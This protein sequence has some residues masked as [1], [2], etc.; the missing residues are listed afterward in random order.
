VRFPPAA[1]TAPIALDD[2]NLLGRSRRS[3]EQFYKID[4]RAELPLIEQDRF[5]AIRH[6]AL[7]LPSMRS[8]TAY[9]YVARR[10]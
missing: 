7:D 1:I 10:G 5:S 8:H 2:I 3:N 4:L 6:A 9:G